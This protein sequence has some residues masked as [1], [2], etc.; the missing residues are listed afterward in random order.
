MPQVALDPGMKV[1]LFEPP[2]QGFRP[3]S[4]SQLTWESTDFRGRSC[5]G[6]LS[7]Q[8]SAFENRHR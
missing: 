3:L 5:T 8:S 1:T 2:P 6:C 7:R 4:A